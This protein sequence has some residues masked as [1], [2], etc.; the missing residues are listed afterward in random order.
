MFHRIGNNAV[1]SY[2]PD[3]NPHRYSQWL[4][5]K[6]LTPDSEGVREASGSVTVQMIEG[7]AHKLKI[8][9]AEVQTHLAETNRQRAFSCEMRMSPNIYCP[10]IYLFTG[11]KYSCAFVTAVLCF[12]SCC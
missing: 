3:Q 1:G 7:S 11:W 4:V 8:G 9:S 6:C 2:K 12:P 5:K 10:R